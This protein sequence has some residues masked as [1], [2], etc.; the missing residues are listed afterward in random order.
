MQLRWSGTNAHIETPGNRVEKIKERKVIKSKVSTRTRLP[1]PTTTCKLH[2]TQSSTTR[3]GTRN[4]LASIAAKSFRTN[5]ASMSIGYNRSTSVL[6]K[7]SYCT[8]IQ[9]CLCNTYLW[10]FFQKIVA[11][12]YQLQPLFD[13][14]RQDVCQN[15]ASTGCFARTGGGRTAGPSHI[16]TTIERS[17]HRFIFVHILF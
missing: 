5:K 6:G 3:C 14:R 16:L 15:H 13:L 11:D 1:S 2:R 17:T 9:Y 4:F 7:C 10:V 8:L 12:R